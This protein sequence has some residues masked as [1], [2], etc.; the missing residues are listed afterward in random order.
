MKTLFTFFILLFSLSALAEES[1]IYYCLSE[2]N[3]GYFVNKNEKIHE[4]SYFEKENF[5]LNI[6]FKKKTMLSEK[7]WL[8]YSKSDYLKENLC[9]NDRKNL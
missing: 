4:M 7:V 8:I 3:I 9:W 2:E 5:I 6:N 1:D